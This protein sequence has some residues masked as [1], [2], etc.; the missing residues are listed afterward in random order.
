MLRDRFKME[1]FVS[2]NRSLYCIRTFNLE[3]PENIC[4]RGDLP[5]GHLYHGDGTFGLM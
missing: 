5:T 4:Y 2:T 1:V 3:N